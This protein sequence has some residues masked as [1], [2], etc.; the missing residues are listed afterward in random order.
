MKCSCGRAN[1][2]LDDDEC[3]QCILHGAEWEREDPTPPGDVTLEDEGE[4]ECQ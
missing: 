4:T 1:V 2:E 3:W